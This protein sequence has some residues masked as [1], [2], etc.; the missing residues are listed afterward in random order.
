MQDLFNL[1]LNTAL[2]LNSPG[3]VVEIEP[4]SLRDLFTEVAI[5]EGVPAKLLRG[6][7]WAESRHTSDAYSHG[8]GSG[9]NHALGICQVLHSTAIYYGFED[10]NCYNDFRAITARTYKQCRLFDSRTS[11]LF[12]AKVLKTM[13]DRYSG[14]WEK[15]AAAYNAG[16]IRICETGEIKRKKDGVV[17]GTCVIGGLFNQ[18]YVDKVMQAIKEER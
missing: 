14:N 11:M 2:I 1:V 7:C 10:K 9:N 15:A 5:A 8:D 17:I 12:G 18:F 13:L 16:S 3:V 6:I 4:K